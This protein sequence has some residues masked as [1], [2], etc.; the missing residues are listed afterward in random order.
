MVHKTLTPKQAIAM[1]ESGLDIKPNKITHRR[2]C[3]SLLVIQLHFDAFDDLL[4]VKSI[5]DDAKYEHQWCTQTFK[6]PDGR[7]YFVLD[8]YPK[9][10]ATKKSDSLHFI[11]QVN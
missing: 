2:A 4:H 9:Q 10:Y 11:R 1:I 6:Y 7:D 3:C 5:L 8:V